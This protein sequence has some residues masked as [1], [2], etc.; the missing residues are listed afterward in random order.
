MNRQYVDLLGVFLVS[1][2]LGGEACQDAKQIRLR[3]TEKLARAIPKL[4]RFIKTRG[5]AF[6]RVTFELL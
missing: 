4:A 2:C 5:N 6:L 3:K 1:S